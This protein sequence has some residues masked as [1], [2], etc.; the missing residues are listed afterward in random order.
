M[1]TDGKKEKAYSL[2][3]EE[4][5]E[6]WGELLD[7]LMQKKETENEQDLIGEEYFEGEIDPLPMRRLVPI[8]EIIEAVNERAWDVCG[9]YAENWPELTGEGKKELEN[10]IAG[11]LEKKA[12]RYFCNYI[13]VRRKTITADDIYGVK[14]ETP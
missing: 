3:E 1:T 10:L 11:F 8:D 6:E 7:M 12:P 2:N 9:E 13:N 4:W 14:E 5:V